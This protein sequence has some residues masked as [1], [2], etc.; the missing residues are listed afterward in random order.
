MISACSLTSGT[1]ERTPSWTEEGAPPARSN[2]R[3]AAHSRSSYTE[4]GGECLQVL[5]NLPAVLLAQALSNVA[6]LRAE[7]VMY[8]TG[9]AREP[10]K[11]SALTAGFSRRN[12]QTAPG[13]KC[14]SCTNAAEHLPL[15][16]LLCYAGFHTCVMPA[17]APLALLCVHTDP[18]PA[19]TTHSRRQRRRCTAAPA[20]AAAHPSA[21]ARPAAVVS[22]RPSRL[23]GAFFL[24]V[25]RNS[26]STG[27]K[28]CA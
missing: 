17:T 12:S 19:T 20:A 3:A 13:S 18:A 15:G 22:G 24:N 7:R 28:S 23:A 11:R 14:V 8:A 6:L 9:L 27:G 1:V 10:S 21:A 5:V 25:W 4:A 26:V 2:S 16:T